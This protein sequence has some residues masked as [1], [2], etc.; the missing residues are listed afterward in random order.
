MHEISSDR[1]KGKVLSWRGTPRNPAHYNWHA[2]VTT[3]ENVYQYRQAP[4]SVGESDLPV[5]ASAG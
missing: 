1:S 2:Y 4:K 3:P 5:L